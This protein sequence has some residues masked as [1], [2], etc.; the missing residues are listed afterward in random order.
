M[1][2][3]LSDEAYLRALERIKKSIEND[4]ILETDDSD[5]IGDKHTHCTWGLCSNLKEHWPDP[6][7]YLWPDQPNRIA[8]KYRNKKQYCP[9]DAEKGKGKQ[10]GCFWTCQIFK[11][12]NKLRK[13]TVLKY[14]EE[15]IIRIKQRIKDKRISDERRAAGKT[16]TTN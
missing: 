14:Y 8:P 9:L 6:N 1:N 2:I 7:D 12:K 4:T 11:F 15:A 13:E 16:E 3:Y 5:I 10:G